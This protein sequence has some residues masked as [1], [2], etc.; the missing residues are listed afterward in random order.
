M[1]SG[2][3]TTTIQSL[4]IRLERHETPTGVEYTRPDAVGVV[5]KYPSVT[6]L[7]GKFENKWYINKWAQQAGEEAAERS[8]TRSAVRGTHVHQA[9]EAFLHRKPIPALVDDE[10][11][12]FDNLKPMLQA[13]I[14]VLSEEKVFWERPHPTSPLGF[15]GTP[16]MVFRLHGAA[17]ARKKSTEPLYEGQRNVLGDFKTWNKMKYPTNLFSNYLQLAAYCGALN[18]RTN[19]YYKLNRAMIIGVT[20]DKLKLY[21]LNPDSLN[22]YWQKFIELTEC[23]FTNRI[24]D[25]NFFVQQSKLEGHVADTVLLTGVPADPEDSDTEP[26]SSTE[27]ESL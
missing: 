11:R 17:L 7:I 23:Y 27:Q 13:V 12:F 14:P 19:G 8:R 20:E 24:F 9:A 4:G 25:W 5:P 6:T 16:D 2:L 21:Y 22:W 3:G 1:V 15:A 18:Q 26:E 10:R